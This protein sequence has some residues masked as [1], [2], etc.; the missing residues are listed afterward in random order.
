VP[1]VHKGR[2]QIQ[3]NCSLNLN[4]LLSFKWNK[5]KVFGFADKGVAIIQIFRLWFRKS[6]ITV[7]D[8]RVRRVRTC[9]LRREFSQPK[10]HLSIACLSQRPSSVGYWSDRFL[11][12]KL[13]AVNKPNLHIF[14]SFLQLVFYILA[15]EGIAVNGIW[16]RLNLKQ[17][18]AFLCSLEYCFTV[19]IYVEAFICVDTLGK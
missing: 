19:R 3:N 12:F 13:Q 15:I 7:G 5:M 11:C 8:G 9:R 17:K 16:P 10:P 1:F 18:P 2:D 6:R 14:N 4:A